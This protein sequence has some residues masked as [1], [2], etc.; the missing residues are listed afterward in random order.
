ML[1]PRIGKS[2]KS[3]GQAT[4]VTDLPTSMP[5]QE[6]YASL[7]H[8]LSSNNTFE[9]LIAYI[10]SFKSSAKRL[11]LEGNERHAIYQDD[12]CPFPYALQTLVKSHWIV[13]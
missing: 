6:Q 12:C 2:S 3:A 9:L 10:L 7:Y 8:D 13:S 5:I 11:V 1:T 4:L